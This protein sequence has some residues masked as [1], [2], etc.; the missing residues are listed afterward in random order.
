GQVRHLTVKRQDLPRWVL[1]RAKAKAVDLEPS[2]AALLVGTIGEETSVLDQA[3]E[4]LAT[5]FPGQRVGVA[6]V[7][8]QFVGLGEQRVWDLCDQAV[9]ARPCAALVTL[10]GLLEARAHHVVVPRG[11]DARVAELRRV[12]G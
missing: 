6:E 8:A 12:R 2:A 4:Q 9:T 7:R 5:A 1:D 3:V 11:I 10:L